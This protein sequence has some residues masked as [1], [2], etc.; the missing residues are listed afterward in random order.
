[1]KELEFAAFQEQEEIRSSFVFRNVYFLDNMLDMQGH[2]NFTNIPSYMHIMQHVYR[3]FNYTQP[4]DYIKCLHSSKR[5]LILHN[6]YP[7]GCLPHNSCF[8]YDVDLDVGHLQHYR[9][10]CTPDLGSICHLYREHIVK[11]TSVWKWKK[12][13]L[14]GASQTLRRLGFLVS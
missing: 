14:R 9:T 8:A 11:D 3:S 10:E 13:V 5:V 1:M 4:G 6:H 12:E 7:L 2:G